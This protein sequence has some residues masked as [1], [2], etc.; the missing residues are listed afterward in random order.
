[1]IATYNCMA[2]K[3]FIVKIKSYYYNNIDIIYIPIE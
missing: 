1:M 2:K 3:P